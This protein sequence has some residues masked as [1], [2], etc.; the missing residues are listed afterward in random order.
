MDALQEVSDVR[1][2]MP[3]AVGNTSETAWQNA[4]ADASSQQMA[5]SADA[6]A[7]KPDPWGWPVA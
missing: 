5:M 3:E 2:P 4:L 7:P 6:A 1:S